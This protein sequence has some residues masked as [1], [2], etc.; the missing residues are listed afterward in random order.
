[1]LREDRYEKILQILSTNAYTT[2][3]Q[4]AQQL[5]V[6]LPTIRRDLAELQKR[7]LLL[8]NHGGA[9]KI[10]AAHFEIP[11]EFRKAC[12]H[13]QKRLLCE[14]AVSLLQDNN[15]LFIDASTTALALIPLLGRFHKLTVITNGIPAALLLQKQGIAAFSTGGEVQGVSLGYAGSHAVDFV[16][17][18]NVDVAFFSSYGVNQQGQI[19]D[20]SLPETDLR[21]AVLQNAKTRVFLCD[22]TKFY[23]DAPYNLCPLQAVDY[24]VTDAPPEMIKGQP[25]GNLIYQF[26]A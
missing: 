9:K 1:M 11:L 2:A 4:L 15:I 20:T 25:I 16:R 3:A 13:A 17:R 12:N 14:A 24:A 5:Y 21:R 8:R 7:N 22:A 26:N 10:D 19:V 18:F 6:S 23:R